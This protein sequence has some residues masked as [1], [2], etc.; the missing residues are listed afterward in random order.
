MGVAVQADGVPAQR[1]GFLGADAGA[2]AQ[3]AIQACIR[4]PADACRSAATWL[5]VKAREGRPGWPGGVAMS[6]ATLTATSLLAMAC[7]IAR[8][9][10]L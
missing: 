2:D 6:S 9:S 5:G 8:V 3:S 10:A 1:A 4:V 7:R